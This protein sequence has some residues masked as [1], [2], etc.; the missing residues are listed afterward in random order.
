MKKRTKKL[1]KTR[2]DFS[3]NL[4][5]GRYVKA[6]LQVGMY[7]RAIADYESVSEGDLGIYKQSNDGTPPAQFAWDG[8]GG[9]TY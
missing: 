7:V 6:N 1:Y 8:L 3:S 9:E 4:D 5:Y 2:E